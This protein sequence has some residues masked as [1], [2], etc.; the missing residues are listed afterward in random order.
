VP[1]T[2]I[3]SIT[4]QLGRLCA[5]LTVAMTLLATLIVVLRYAFGLGWVGLQESAV[6]LHAA[7]SWAIKETSSDAGGLPLVYLL[8]SLIPAMA[9]SLGL[10]GCA[11][12]I[13]TAMALL[14]PQPT[15]A[16]GTR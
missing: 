4:R 12:L 1:L 7:A 8:K 11:E 2:L 6:Y 14:Q 5:A 13:Q 10:Q 16:Q 9:C 15:D 3:N